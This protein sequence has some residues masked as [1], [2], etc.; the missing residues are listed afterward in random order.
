[1]NPIARTLDAVGGATADIFDRALGRKS[2]DSLA[3]SIGPWQYYGFPRVPW[4][5]DITD[6]GSHTAS[7]ITVTPATALRQPA[8]WAAVRVLSED[9]AKLPLIVYRHLP[10]GGKERARDHAL[11]TVLHD[12]ANPEM[13]SYRW[14]QTMMGHLLTW[15]NC[16]SEKVYDRAGR[17]QLWP[18]KPERIDIYYDRQ[19][20]RAYRYRNPDGTT[21]DLR[22]DTVFHVAG[23][24]YDGLRGY[25]PI[26]MARETI[27]EGTAA[28]TFATSW[29]R[30]GARPSGIIEVPREWPEK[31]KQDF[32]DAWKNANEG[33]GNAGKTAM[34]PSG[35]KYTPLTVSLEDAQF[36][37]TRKHNVTDIARW[38]RLPPHKLGDLEH[39]TFSNIE[40]QS[41]EY[42]RDSLDPWL[43]NWEQEL[44]L[45]LM[46]DDGDYF[47]EFLRDALLRGDTLA[48]AQ[49]NQIRLR[50]GTLTPDEWR[51]QE[52][53]N[54]YP[55]GLGARPLLS[56]DLIP[57]APAEEQEEA[58]E[59]A[60]AQQP[61]LTLVK[62]ARAVLM[63]ETREHRAS[64]PSP[65]N[66][67][68]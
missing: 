14:R 67:K 5:S 8:V 11:Y 60:A 13:T 18:I 29:W 38:F 55:D 57:A 1:M 63:A 2:L 68:S 42:V 47:A 7:G 65:A 32:K 39:A 58:L 61:R 64:E 15:G 40:H 6:Y 21:K 46:P 56:A 44:R 16:Y 9:V 53:Q 36:L 17:L 45:Q 50:N 59:E 25:S 41:I 20:R 48:R 37:E 33:A 24:G 51:A 3:E 22:P 26:T 27:A 4:E 66:G 52:N 12:I 10:G 34:L 54:P 43:V 28:Q 23:F 31:T 35:A 49:A 30:R 19:G 62:A